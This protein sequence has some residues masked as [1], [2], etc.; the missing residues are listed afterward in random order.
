[1][2]TLGQFRQENG[3][4]F[5]C[6][7]HLRHSFSDRS[8]LKQLVGSSMSIPAEELVPSSSDIRRRAAAFMTP[9]RTS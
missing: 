7:L 9:P 6:P 2:V 1:M 4:I 8:V 5:G 3:Y